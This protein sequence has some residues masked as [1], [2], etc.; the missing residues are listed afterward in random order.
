[1]RNR[2]N[3]WEQDN[4]NRIEPN[5]NVDLDLELFEHGYDFREDEFDW[6]NIRIISFV[7]KLRKGKN[8]FVDL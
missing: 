7:K 2:Y 4:D 5:I 8:K 3:Y 6:N 1:M